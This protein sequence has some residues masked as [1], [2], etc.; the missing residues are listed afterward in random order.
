MWSLGFWKM[1]APN[2]VGENLKISG[3]FYKDSYQFKTTLLCYL[4][5]KNT[6]T[7]SKEERKPRSELRYWKFHI[8]QYKY[9][10][11]GSGLH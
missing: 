3:V 8:F 4:L 6:L 10:T 7:N 5:K 9:S 11:L 1:G 2:Y